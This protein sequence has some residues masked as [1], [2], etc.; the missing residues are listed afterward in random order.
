MQGYMFNW[1]HWQGRGT[2][3]CVTL[4]L[5]GR[6]PFRIC[7]RAAATFLICREVV[8]FCRKVTRHLRNVQD[9]EKSWSVTS[10]SF[11]TPRHFWTSLVVID[12]LDIISFHL[13]LVFWTSFIIIS[14]RRSSS[15]LFRCDSI[16]LSHVTVGVTVSQWQWQ[17]TT[18]QGVWQCDSVTVSQCVSDSD[19]E[20]EI[21][22][23]VMLSYLRALRAISQ[24]K[25]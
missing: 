25:F 8:H 9:E 24:I 13:S 2:W 23:S 19:S 11:L 18:C 4:L 6:C 17:L 1:L 22:S 14:P 12:T 20:S 5:V 10:L 21:V 16:F 15:I 3:L 7:C